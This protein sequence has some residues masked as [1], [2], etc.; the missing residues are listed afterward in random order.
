MPRTAAAL[1]IGN[2]ILSGKIQETNLALLA[3]E[4]FALGVS[5]RRVVVCP[6]EVDTIVEDLV[7][8][9]T[10]HDY[11]ITSGGVGPT[12][13]DVTLLAVAQSFGRPLVRSPEME[14]LIRSFV[15]GD[16]TR[17]HL[18][19]ANVPEGAELLCDDE[20][21]WPTILVDNVFVM[22]GLPKVFRMKIPVLRRYL[23]GHPPFLSRS[24]YTLCH[25]TE[26]AELLDRLD[27]EH[28]RVSIGSY[29]V[30]GQAYK[31]KLTFDGSD[32]RAIDRCAEALLAELPLDKVVPEP[33]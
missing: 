28:E 30:T 16:L 11:V 5:L 24:V 9:R 18:R 21:R 7:H 27:A 31:V 19:M 14:E 2:E 23:A 13:D 29:P 25:E 10:H 8:L 17:G 4:L 12:H 3:Q 33:E 22:P 32:A 6:D 20:V 26:L 15:G 1:I